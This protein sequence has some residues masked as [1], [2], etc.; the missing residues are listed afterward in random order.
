MN[1]TRMLRKLTESKRRNL[2]G[3][4]NVLVVEDAQTDKDVLS[5]NGILKKI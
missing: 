1:R 4:T 2:I 3:L 5:K